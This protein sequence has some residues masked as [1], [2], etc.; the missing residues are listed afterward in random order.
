MNTLF[1]SYSRSFAFT[2]NSATAPS[3]NPIPM[4]FTNPTACSTTNRRDKKRK[5]RKW[6]R[7][8]FVCIYPIHESDL[9]SHESVNNSTHSIQNILTS[10][11]LNNIMR[12]CSNYNIDYLPRMNFPMRLPTVASKE[13]LV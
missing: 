4:L 2:M 9:S 3:A 1:H 12:H 7:Q 13:N 11:E 5:W 8:L 10:E 6:I